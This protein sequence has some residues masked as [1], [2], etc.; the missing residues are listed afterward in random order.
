MQASPSAIT[1]FQVW[2]LA[3][4]IWS[5]LM[6]AHCGPHLT[7]SH[8]SSSHFIW[9]SLFSFHLTSHLISSNLISSHVG[10]SQLL[11]HHL[12]SSPFTSSLLFSAHPSSSH[13]ISACLISSHVNSVN[14]TLFN[15]SYLPHSSAGAV[16]FFFQ[17]FSLLLSSHLIF[18]HLYF[19]VLTCCIS[20]L[21]QNL[22]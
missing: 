20:D 4:F 11:L 18:R 19:S 13:V 14:L 10:S 5:H 6:S 3:H 1:S 2:N 15:S 7:S 12:I 17:I 16:V 21:A 9:S 22:L 8:L